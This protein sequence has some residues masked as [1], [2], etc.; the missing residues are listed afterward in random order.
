LRET[1]GSKEAIQIFHIRRKGRNR[2][3]SA[4]YKVLID[5]CVFD[6]DIPEQSSVRIRFGYV[7]FKPY[8]F[9]LYK[10]PI[11]IGGLPCETFHEYPRIRRFRRIDADVSD[12][13]AV[14]QF[15]RI[16]VNNPPNR[17]RN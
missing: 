9:P 5:H 2:S 8:I 17:K 11:F 3:K 15:N 14:G 10:N 16:T 12:A 13:P 7:F 4:A 1:L 6:V